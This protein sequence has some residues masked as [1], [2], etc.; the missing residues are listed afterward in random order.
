MTDD[1]KQNN[2][3]RAWKAKGQMWYECLD[4]Y[5]SLKV[6]FKY[7]GCKND[8]IYLFLHHQPFYTVANHGLAV[9][10]VRKVLHIADWN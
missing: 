4:N 5:F 10:N 6:V 9:D 1:K 8:I 7:S 3:A 2:R